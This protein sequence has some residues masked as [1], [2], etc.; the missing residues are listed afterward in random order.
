MGIFSVLMGIW[1]R[2]KKD[3]PPFPL[4]STA[5]HSNSPPS[6]LPMVRN[7]HSVPKMVWDDKIIHSTKREGHI[8]EKLVYYKLSALKKVWIK[9]LSTKDNELHSAGGRERHKMLRELLRED[10]VLRESKQKLWVIPTKSDF[11]GSTQGILTNLCTRLCLG[12]HC[13][14]VFNLTATMHFLERY[15]FLKSQLHSLH[16]GK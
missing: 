3:K 10:H 1:F 5:V 15:L 16:T 6:S 14:P 11:A 13:T 2:L 12:I 4:C 7:C 8:H 9:N